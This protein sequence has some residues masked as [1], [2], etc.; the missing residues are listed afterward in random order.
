MGTP[1]ENPP[2]KKEYIFR[3]KIHKKTIRFD[4]DELQKIN[5]IIAPHNIKFSEFARS[6]ILNKKIK[7]KI[8]IEFIYQIKKIGTNLNQIAKALNQ[9][10]FRNEVELLEQLFKIETQLK[11]LKNDN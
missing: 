11:N 1:P 6:A 3:N 9:N 7:S 4:D 2:E 10:N 5:E 8:E